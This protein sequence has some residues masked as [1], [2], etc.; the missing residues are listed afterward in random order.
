M[1]QEKDIKLEKELQK[2]RG[3]RKRE[4]IAFIQ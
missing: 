4:D 3:E 1:K 2:E